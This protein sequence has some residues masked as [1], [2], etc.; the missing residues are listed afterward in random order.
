MPNGV[1]AGSSPSL[2]F[3]TAVPRRLT[4]TYVSEGHRSQP[5]TQTARRVGK[6]AW[7]TVDGAP[8]RRAIPGRRRGQVLGTRAAHVGTAREIFNARSIWG[9]APSPTLRPIS[10]DVFQSG[11]LLRL[12]TGLVDHLAPQGRFLSKIFG[13]LGPRG[14]P[15]LE[16]DILQYRAHLFLVENRHDVAIDLLRN[17]CRSSRGCRKPKPGDRFEPWESG[18]RNGGYL[19]DNVGAPQISYADK[20]HLAVAIERQRS[21]KRVEE[22]IYVAGQHVGEGRLSA[23]IGYVY[24]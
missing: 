6:I 11:Q 14:C 13:R 12:Y 16:R 8:C 15:R 20:L 24:H 10:D 21:R 19:G 22:H 1:L 7:P 2:S 18:F 9:C 17:R 3:C 5:K 4:L 23:A